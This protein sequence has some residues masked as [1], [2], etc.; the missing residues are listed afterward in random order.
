MIP[1][2]TLAVTYSH[3]HIVPVNMVKNT[4][5]HSHTQNTMKGLDPY[6]IEYVE[7]CN[8]DAGARKM[9]MGQEKLAL[10]QNLTPAS[11]KPG[12]QIV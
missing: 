4:R 12:S 2:I 8:Q 3:S 11:L 9:V 7:Y 10:Q 6:I 1:Q 5:S